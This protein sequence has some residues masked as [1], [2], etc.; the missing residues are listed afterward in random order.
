MCNTH[1]K[2]LY[3]YANFLVKFQPNI[4]QKKSNKHKLLI[5]ILIHN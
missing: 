1:R 4:K 2:K 3:K 5:N